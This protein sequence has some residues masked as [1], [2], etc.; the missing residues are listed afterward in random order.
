MKIEIGNWADGETE[1][2]AGGENGFEVESQDDSGNNTVEGYD[3]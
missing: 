3:V 2:R 1:S